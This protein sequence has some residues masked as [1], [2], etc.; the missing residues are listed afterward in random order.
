[1]QPEVFER[2]IL[3]AFENHVAGVVDQ[4][5]E[6]AVALIDRVK[7]GVP[8]ILEADIERMG[9]TPDLVG[10]RLCLGQVNIRDDHD[11]AFFGKA[12]AIRLAQPHRPARHQSHLAV[13]SS[14]HVH[15]PARCL[16]TLLYLCAV[17]SHTV[18]SA[19]AACYFRQ[20]RELHSLV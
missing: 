4:D 5:I 13:D 9:L 10:H 20:A 12:D 19:R 16:S 6:P 1:M 11:R 8:L 18:E 3:D 2:A 17:A 7:H 14:S 15:L